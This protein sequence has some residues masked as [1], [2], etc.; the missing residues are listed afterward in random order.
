MCLSIEFGLCDIS[1]MEYLGEEGYVLYFVQK[2]LIFWGRIFYGDIL[3]LFCH[4]V[5]VNFYYINTIVEK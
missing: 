1:G 3:V 4:S 2:I 5:K